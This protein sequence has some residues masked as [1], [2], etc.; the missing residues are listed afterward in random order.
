MSQK[1]LLV[2]SPFYRLMGSHFNGLHLGIAYIAA[3]L[4]QHGHEVRIYNADYQDGTNYLNQRQLFENFPSYK[5]ALNDLENPIWAEVKKNIADYAPDLV[6]ITMLTAN[7]KAA[8]NMARMIKKMDHGVKIAVGGAHATLDPEGTIEQD[9]LDY[10][11]RGE[12]EST[13]LELVDGRNERDILG[14]SWKRNTV[15]VHNEER[16]FVEN[17]NELPFP[18]RDAFLNELSHAELGYV[19]TG[20]GCPYSCSYCASPRLWHGTTRFRSIDN[21]LEELAYLKENLETQVIHFT[22]DTFNLNQKRTEDLCQRIIENALD[23]QWVC[24]ARIDHLEPGL[25]ELM[26]EAGCVR[27]KIG[28]ESGSDRILKSIHKGTNREMIRKG[29]AMIKAAGIPMTIYLMA[30]FPDE[31]NADLR[32]TIELAREVD[33]DYYSLSILAPYYGTK[34]WEELKQSNHKLEKEHWEYFY[35][36]SQE[37]IVCDDLDPCIVSEFLALNEREGKGARF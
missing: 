16:P 10:V 28:V 26:K 14:L 30:G 12:G 37:M 31:T 32:Q 8:I 25:L 34:I 7:Y 6:G 4:R 29:A 35:H 19:M 20:R 17:L 33:A 21:V 27:V 1:I 22:D 24:E 23:V 11:I 2:A 13:F 36:Q 3:V 18:A 5:V 9:E 15:A